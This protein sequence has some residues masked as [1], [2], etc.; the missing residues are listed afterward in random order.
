MNTAAILMDLKYK[1]LRMEAGGVELRKWEELVR[2]RAI[3]N[4]NVLNIFY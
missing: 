4:G 1:Y 3:V 2:G